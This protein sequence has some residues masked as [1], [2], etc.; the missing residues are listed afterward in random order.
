M[1]SRIS[2]SK[3][4]RSMPNMSRLP[5]N[6]AVRIIIMLRQV[7][8]FVPHRPL[9]RC[10]ELC[11]VL[12]VLRCI[13]VLRLQIPSRTRQPLILWKLLSMARWQAVMAL[14]HSVLP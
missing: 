10:N 12:S 11:V 8:N 1:T 5:P 14:L 2:V 9:A 4:S 13:D 7:T 6:V 3:W